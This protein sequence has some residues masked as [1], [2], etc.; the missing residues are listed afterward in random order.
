MRAA[1]ISVSDAAVAAPAGQSTAESEF[2]SGRPRS[3]SALGPPGPP[4]PLRLHLGELTPRAG[5]AAYS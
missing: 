1:D 2:D 4:S 5:R 3:S